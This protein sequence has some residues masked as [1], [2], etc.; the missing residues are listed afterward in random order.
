MQNGGDLG[1][2][3]KILHEGLAGLQEGAEPNRIACL[4]VCRRLLRWSQYADLEGVDMAGLAHL[5]GDLG[6]P[7]GR[8]YPDP[9]ARAVAAATARTELAAALVAAGGRP[10]DEPDA[11]AR[12]VIV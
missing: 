9:N 6:E 7:P 3:R 4:W 1:M 5:L 8:V 12:V 11:P 2:L 10:D